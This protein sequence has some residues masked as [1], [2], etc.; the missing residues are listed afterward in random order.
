M[1]GSTRRSR[2]GSRSLS[3]MAH[4]SA[5]SSNRRRLAARACK[6]HPVASLNVS[7]IILVVD[8]SESMGW[9]LDDGG[10]VMSP[11]AALA[12]PRPR[13]IEEVEAWIPRLVDTMAEIPETYETAA[14]AVIAFNHEATVKRHLSM[15][16]AGDTMFQFQASGTTSFAAALRAVGS[17]LD[18]HLPSL[19]S[20]GFRPAVSGSRMASLSL[21]LKTCGS[22]SAPG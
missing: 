11:E 21:R 4:G 5:S 20:S 3:A 6:V 22:P 16:R 14:L 2:L 19:S 10:Q 1:I 15:L 8:C 12:D 17:Q 9:L 13:P 7:P 18:N